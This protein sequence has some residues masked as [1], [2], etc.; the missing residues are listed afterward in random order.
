MLDHGVPV[1]LVLHSLLI[2]SSVALMSSPQ[3]VMA[4]NF[5]L[6]DFLPFRCADVVLRMDE[7]IPQEAF[8]AHDPHELFRRQLIPFVAINLAIVDLTGIVSSQSIREALGSNQSNGPS[9]W[10]PVFCAADPSLCRRSCR[11]TQR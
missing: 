10:E 3:L 4:E 7:G 9:M 2:E 6:G 8:M 5:L 11:P 1:S